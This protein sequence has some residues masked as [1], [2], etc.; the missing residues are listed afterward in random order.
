MAVDA[1]EI[2]ELLQKNFPDGEISL[3]D[4]KGDQDHYL[5]SLKSSAFQG[6]TLI[7]QHKMVYTALEGK[8][9]TALHALALKTQ[10]K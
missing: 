4:L 1:K 5:L 2:Q 6:K 9:G 3:T 10:P 7:Q 8:V